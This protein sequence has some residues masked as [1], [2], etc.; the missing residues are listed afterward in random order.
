M[1]KREKE[2]S[3]KGTLTDT[4]GVMAISQPY[5]GFD[6]RRSCVWLREVQIKVTPKGM[7][8]PQTLLTDHCREQS[9]KKRAAA[10]SGNSPVFSDTAPFERGQRFIFF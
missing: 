10:C 4:Y 9:Q 5:V 2:I 1:D 8:A 6:V 7:T 3:G